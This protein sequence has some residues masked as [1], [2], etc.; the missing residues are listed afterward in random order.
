[1]HD[2]I[3]EKLHKEYLLHGYITEQK[4][5]ATIEEYDVPLFDVEY[6]CDQLLSKGVLI[7]DD[8]AIE[9]SA[10]EYD[11]S[12]T[13]YSAL[14]EQV[15]EI[16]PSLTHFVEY[17]KKVQAPQH[18]EWQNLLPHAQNGNEYARSR[19]FE[20]YMRV[21]LKMALSISQKY[22]LD[23]A[24]A[25]QN[26]MIGLYIAIEKFEY[27][28][29]DVF[30][31]YFPFWVRQVILREAAL[32]RLIPVPAHV[33]DELFEIKA[34][35]KSENFDLSLDNIDEGTQLVCTKMEIEYGKAKKLIL[36]LLPAESLHLDEDISL[37]SDYI[38]DE[39]EYRITTNLTNE[40]LCKTINRLLLTLTPRE[41]DVIRQRYGLSS[42]VPKTLEEVANGY[43]LTKERVRQIE[44]KALR[45]LKHST[46]SKELRSFFEMWD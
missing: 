14:Y 45:K 7:R 42:D 41:R 10:E 22:D 2:T 26:G 40:E 38:D 29:N 3:V 1:M 39:F 23:V 18:R 16:D 37:P 34:L 11:R 31:T 8:D 15:L 36:L 4:V 24:E 27:G 6:I 46:R 43:G 28:K 44:A 32:D 12:Q 35:L 17:I 5:F 33:S 25:I 30:P 21:V 9:D 20:M 13:D 19:I